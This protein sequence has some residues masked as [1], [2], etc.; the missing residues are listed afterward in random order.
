MLVFIIAS[1]SV[2]TLLLL[3]NKE[4]IELKKIEIYIEGMEPS[5]NS[6]KII[7]ISDFHESPR[8]EE[9]LSQIRKVDTD[10]FCIS[11]DMV[12]ARKNSHER[13]IF[14]ISELRKMADVYY[15]SGNH[16]ARYGGYEDFEKKLKD[17]GVKVLNNESDY[18]K[19]RGFKIL[20]MGISDPKFKYTAYKKNR[21]I[22][23]RKFIEESLRNMK[24]EEIFTLLLSHRPEK[25]D[26][27]VKYGI[28]LVL[29]G[30]AHGGQIILPFV[31]GLYSP[32]QGF[33][34]KYFKGLYKNNKTIMNVSAGLGPS[35]FPLRI[36]NP[37]EVYL[38]ELKN[39][40][41]KI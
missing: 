22:F 8:Y 34:P 33:F 3:K 38:I 37:Y 21:E 5:F 36:N 16:E 25:F 23:E 17:M 1:L 24:D 15:V 26:I 7:H 29:S 20:I 4:R 27:Y 12:D 30:H 41:K 14:F 10:I 28:D 9:I 6:F 35:I 11:G 40:S 2:L 13:S 19:K 39:S 18:I 32:N 31:G